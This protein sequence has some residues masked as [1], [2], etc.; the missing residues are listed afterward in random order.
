MGHISFAATTPRSWTTIVSS[1]MIQIKAIH[2]KFTAWTN[3]T[4]WGHGQQYTFIA[5]LVRRHNFLG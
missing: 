3:D 1:I 5:Q 4:P 2:E